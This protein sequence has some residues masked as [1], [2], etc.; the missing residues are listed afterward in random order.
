[1]TARFG[2]GA[3]TSSAWE[4]HGIDDLALELYLDPTNGLPR[5]TSIATNGTGGLLIT[6]T[7]TPTQNYSLEASTNLTTW[8]WRAN[9]IVGGGGVWQFLEP[10]IS[11]PRYRFYRLR[12]AP[13]FP[14]GLVTWY[15]AE[16]N[17]LD[18]FGP[19]HGTTTN[20][21]AFTAGQRGQAFSFDGTNSSMNIG[22][23][24]LPPPWTAAL[25]VKRQQSQ[26]A[27][28]I[29]LADAVQALKLEQFGIATRP[30]GFT[31]YA[32][33]DYAF[34]YT[35]PSNAWVHLTFVG[36]SSNT[37]LYVNGT[38]QDTNAASIGLPLGT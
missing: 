23:I 21:L 2:L 12:S 19:N 18:S 34:N 37:L 28:S 13:Q 7:G 31:R 22:A 10:I 6:G 11:T 30:V 33:A 27:S 1:M 3:R 8:T 9:I 17:T 36:T 16:N 24:A 4:T 14:P 5:I 15:R 32:V 26:D 20:N 25:W 35:A 29:L 38:A